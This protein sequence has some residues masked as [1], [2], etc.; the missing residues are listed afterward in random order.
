[1]LFDLLTCPQG[2]NSNVASTKPNSLP[3]SK[4]NTVTKW[5]KVFFFCKFTPKN[6]L[7]K[8]KTLIVM[9]TGFQKQ[10]IYKHGMHI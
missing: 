3:S 10:S 5:K 2:N 1:M 7:W 4:R 6:N 8:C 9:E